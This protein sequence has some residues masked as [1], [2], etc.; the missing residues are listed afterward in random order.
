MNWRTLIPSNHP[1]HLRKGAEIEVAIP[2]GYFSRFA[3]YSVRTSEWIKEPGNIHGGYTQSDCFYRVR[4]AATVTLDEV[5]HGIRPNV[6]GE[7]KTLDETLAAIET[8]AQSD[9]P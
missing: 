3:I 7:Y 5:R 8:A 6:I 9:A 1:D 4:D 2:D